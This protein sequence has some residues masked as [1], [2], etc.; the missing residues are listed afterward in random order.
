MKSPKLRQTSKECI[1]AFLL[2]QT[3]IKYLE[4]NETLPHLSHNLLLSPLRRAPNV[5]TPAEA[6]H[7]CNLQYV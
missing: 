5:T 7:L 1:L 4:R 2:L 6:I 3:E